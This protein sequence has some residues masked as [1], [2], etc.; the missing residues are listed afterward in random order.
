MGSVHEE[1]RARYGAAA[2][3]ESEKA[4]D[5][6]GESADAGSSCCGGAQADSRAEATQAEGSCCGGSQSVQLGDVRESEASSCC[7]DRGGSTAF[8]YSI[9]ELKILPD[10]ADLALGCGNPTAIA[11][12]SAGETVVDLGS[13]GGIDCFL[14]SARVGDEGRVIGVDMTSDMIELAR[15]NATKAGATNVEFR[16]GEIEHLPIADDTADL[17]ISNCVINLSP[18]K[19]QVFREAF[20]VLAPG[21]RFTVSD[22]VV[23]G[24]ITEDISSNTALL[25]GCIAGAMNRDDFLQGL[26]DAGF[27]DVRVEKETDYIK[28]EHLQGIAA[29]AGISEAT[30]A[31]IAAKHKSAT[32]YARKP[33]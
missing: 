29:E 4:T 15:R 8:G 19:H 25:T 32:I 14:A 16:L 23:D 2:R 27:E 6:C 30:I 17:I 1:V 31:E 20:R 33:E 11:S 18:D 10:G 12:I 24:E 7:G 9:E 26:R 5:C 28:L 13:G 3:Q 22:V 21:G